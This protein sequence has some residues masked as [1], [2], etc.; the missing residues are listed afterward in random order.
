MGLQKI[1]SSEKSLLFFKQRVT[2][3]YPHSYE[4]KSEGTMKNKMI[5]WM[6]GVIAVVVALMVVIVV[7]EP[8]GEGITRAQAFKAAALLTASKEQCQSY[9]EESEGSHFSVKEQG[10][11][12]VKY[13]DYLY[14]EGYLTEELTPPTLAA[15]QGQ[16]TYGEA[17]QIAEKVD[18]K[19]RTRVGATKNNQD[20]PYPQEQW[21]QMYMEMAGILDTEGKIQNITAVLYGT[22]SNLEGADSWTAYTTEGDF[23]FEGLALDAYL[24]CQIRFLA[25]DGEMIA[26]LEL[27]SRDAAYEN[28]WIAQGEGSSFQAYLGSKSR[29][30]TL[31]AGQGTG[32]ELKNNLADL[33]LRDGKLTK[34]TLK[35]ERI[36]GKVLAVTDTYIE[37][38]GYGRLELAP[39]FQVYR[40]YGGFALLDLSDILV[41]YDLQEFAAADGKLCAALVDREF[42]ASTIRVLLMDTGFQSCFHPQVDLKLNGAAVLEYED[43]DGN[44]HQ[45]ELEA[46]SGFS[47]TP[48]DE[49]LTYSGIIIRP[50]ENDAITITSIERSQGTPVYDGSLEIRRE[51][52]GLVLVNDLYLEDYLT[53]VV[54]SEMP[55]SYEMEAL[56]A[57]AVCARTYAY[58]QIQGNAYSQYGAHVDDSTN[59]QVYNNTDTNSKTD[60]AVA[61]TYGQ[62]L[63]W[64]GNAIEAFYFSTSC[65]H[66]TD[67]SV[68][69][70]AGAALPY[71]EAVELRERRE[72]L[73]LT[74][75]ETF[76]E[77]IRNKNISSYDSS[78]PMYRWN[79][80][81]SAELLSS[82]IEGV[83]QVQNMTVTQRGPGGIAQEIQIQGSQGTS[84]I[85]TQSKIRSVLGDA[86]LVIHR[87]DGTDLE[88][89]ATL[90]S[91]FISIHTQKAEDGS[92]GFQIY[93]GGYG[94]GVGMSQNG[95][96]GMAREG[97]DY[98][99]I[100]D[101][102]YRGADLVDR[103]EENETNTES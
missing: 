26:M 66:T 38:E 73:D 14:D 25:R 18:R 83:G 54:P 7:L 85:R 96:Q 50:E 23:G 46:D 49:R 20:K 34:I 35:K 41:G 93:G 100:L 1:K 87:N 17:A 61:A 63:F 56:K 84:Q 90:P 94:H 6:A 58:R 92:I 31:E 37:L 9:E 55:P 28:V 10:N 36:H 82:K 97:K 78:F 15:A 57:Q 33:Q 52:E 44:L 2:V 68:W 24:D 30:F 74:D 39:N 62:M 22:P 98:K 76:D 72:T 101:F 29:E 88:G 81:I 42:D 13:M 32:D 69:G 47:I 79:T 86:S 70:A 12:F 71:L 43:A 16:L 102:F 65:G 99:E 60:E 91:A 64:D 11:W 103:L 95:A 59:Y 80:W 51:E 21:W 27:V 53:K 3:R 5:A 40:L 89:S 4:Q 45:E 67:G 8:E 48:E 75:N 19:L 77:F